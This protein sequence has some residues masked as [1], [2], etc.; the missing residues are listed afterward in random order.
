MLRVGLMRSGA[1]KRAAQ[2]AG[3]VR[4]KDGGTMA[5]RIGDSALATPDATGLAQR[6][7]PVSRERAPRLTERLLAAAAHLAILL[8]IP[9]TLLA[10]AIWLTQ[11]H[12][13]PYVSQQ[14]RQAVLWQI[15]SNVVLAILVALLLG[16]A[17]SQL[18]A[19]VSTKSGGSQGDITRMFG[20][21]LGIYVVLFAAL[22]YCCVSAVLGACF[23][24]LGRGFH[25]PIVGRKRKM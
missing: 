5:E 13:S 9:G 21:L 16:V 3:R 4:E 17:V 2:S 6:S 25:Y 12:R 18:G 10:V 14:A 8:S 20:S 1:A 19:A 11:R 23:A 22:I 7:R 15:L 24:L